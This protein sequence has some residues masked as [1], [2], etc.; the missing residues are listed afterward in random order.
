MSTDSFGKKEVTC[1]ECGGP[2]TTQSLPSSGVIASVISCS[3][4]DY[5]N[6]RRDKR[7]ASTRAAMMGD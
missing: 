4:C 7:P 6:V 1:P 5:R 3:N 2:L